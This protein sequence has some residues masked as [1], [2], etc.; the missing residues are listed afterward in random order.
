MSSL[1]IGLESRH[2]GSLE[3]RASD[4]CPYRT[5]S[6]YHTRAVAVEAVVPS[7]RVSAS[8]EGTPRGQESGWRPCAPGVSS[9]FTRSRFPNLHHDIIITTTRWYLRIKTRPRL[10]EH[11][12]T[13]V[14]KGEQAHETRHKSRRKTV[15]AD[16][17]RLKWYRNCH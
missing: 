2:L 15:K 5:K 16:R 7:H 3:I 14:N 10:P 6:L 1:G 8:E 13:E 11:R 9:D 12:V 4:T 17:S